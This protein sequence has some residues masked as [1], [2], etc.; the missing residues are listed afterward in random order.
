MKKLW[1]FKEH[2]ARSVDHKARGLQPGEHVVA[3]FQ[4]MPASTLWIVAK[5]AAREK[6]VAFMKGHS[7]DG[8]LGN[9]SWVMDIEVAR[10]PEES[11]KWLGGHSQEVA[12]TLVGD[13]FETYFT[14][15]CQE[16]RGDG[17]FDNPESYRDT[18]EDAYLAG[19]AS[20]VV[21]NG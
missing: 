16:K 20:K 17:L 4:E 8:E 12:T 14:E 13:D 18:I 11:V 21:I 6:A 7:R 5:Q 2:V 10:I 15:W 1:I 19:A 3:V 9:V